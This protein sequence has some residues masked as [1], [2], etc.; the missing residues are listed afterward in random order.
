LT[1]DG[2]VSL[3]HCE[4]GKQIA[5]QWGDESWVDT[6]MIQYH[7]ENLDGTGHYGLSW[8][9]LNI[10]TR[11]IR[12][13]DSYDK[14]TKPSMNND[15]HTMEEAFE[16]LYRWSDMIYDLSVVEQFYKLIKKSSS[17]FL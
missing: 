10:Q 14:M 4:M 13:T 7:H 5:K 12:V 1:Q 9:Q 11:I 6:D 17:T 16:E 3:E 8:E 15:Q 2:R